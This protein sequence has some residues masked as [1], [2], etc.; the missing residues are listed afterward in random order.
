MWADEEELG[1][2]LKEA[3][4]GDGPPPGDHLTEVL[5]RGRRGVLLR[6]A[7]AVAASVFIAGGLCV[8]GLALRGFSLTPPPPANGVT[9]PAPVPSSPTTTTTGAPPAVPETNGARPGSGGS[10]V[11]PGTTSHPASTTPTTSTTTT[12]PTTTT[13]GKC[14]EQIDYGSDPRSNAEINSIGESTGTCPN[15]IWNPPTSPSEGSGTPR[16]TS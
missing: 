6:R 13:S 4:A 10:A 7:G 11:P 3:V 14:T 5:R 1:L 16:P 8:G 9:T 15:P 12:G 2:A